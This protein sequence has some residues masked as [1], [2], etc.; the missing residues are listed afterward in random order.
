MRRGIS[1]ALA[2]R[3]SRSSRRVLTD[4][5]NT[6]PA[7]PARRL[8]SWR[9]KLRAFYAWALSFVCPPIDFVLKQHAR[10]R[11][12]ERG[13]S[14]EHVWIA[15]NGPY[16]HDHDWMRIIADLGDADLN[17]GGGWIDDE[18]FGVTTVF[19]GEK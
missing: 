6:L 19:W 5:R 8:T 4:Y 9:Y 7:P 10:E 16:V 15:L 3:L 14:S 1:F 12:A 17:V 18:T 2:K 11:M 13:V